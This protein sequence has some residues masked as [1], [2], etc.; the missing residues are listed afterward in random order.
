[1]FSI[2]PL[3]VPAN[4]MNHKGSLNLYAGIKPNSGIVR[5]LSPVYIV[6]HRVQVALGI[7]KVFPDLCHEDFSF[8]DA[9]TH[10][11]GE[12]SQSEWFDAF[13]HLF[14]LIHA[15]FFELLVFGPGAD[16]NLIIR[17]S[18]TSASTIV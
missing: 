1:M 9:P 7:S 15:K 14:T 8:P 18:I 5:W 3:H 16:W 17:V 6:K 12:E 13:N 2:Y 4:E 10:E 11:A